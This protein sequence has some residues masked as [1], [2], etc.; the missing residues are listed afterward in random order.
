MFILIFDY[1]FFIK[2]EK[3]FQKQ[4]IEGGNMPEEKKEENVVYVGKK[5][6]MGYVLAVLTQFSQGSKEVLLK[7]R[8]KLTAKAITVAEV[9][10]NKYISNVEVK[11]VKIGTEEL[12]SEDGKVNR[13]SSI[14]ITLVKK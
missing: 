5:P 10:K 14:E 3:V 7:A 6:T 2:G 9:V 13:V 12:T 11:N 8:G 1:N 4:F